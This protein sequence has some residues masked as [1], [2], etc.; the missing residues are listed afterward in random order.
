VLYLGPVDTPINPRYSEQR[1]ASS[2]L[3]SSMPDAAACIARLLHSERENFYF[4][5]YI[6]LALTAL[7]WLPDRWFML[8]T[9]PLRRA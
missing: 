4:P 5:F 2:P 3:V 1:P 6:F 9:S 8:L 7:A